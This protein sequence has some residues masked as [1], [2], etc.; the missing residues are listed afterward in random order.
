M[1]IISV[2]IENINSLKGKWAIDFTHDDYAKNNNQFVICG[3][4]GSGK[5]TILDAITLALYGKTPREQKINT[6]VNEVI[7]KGTASCRAVVVYECNNEVITS[8]FSQSK[9]VKSG[10][11]QKI[12]YKVKNDTLGKSD[13]FSTAGDLEKKTTEITGLTYDQ[14]CKSVLLAQ[15]SFSSF[16]KGSEREKAEIL[17]KLNGTED[18]KKAANILWEDVNKKIDSN[19]RKIEKIDS[20]ETLSEE[21]KTELSNEKEE[22]E[23]ALD[24]LDNEKKGLD[25]NIAWK[26]A[27]L[28]KTDEL[29]RAQAKKDEINKQI[30]EFSK[31]KEKLE[32]AEKASKCATQYATYKS[33]FDNIDNINKKLKDASDNLDAA[34]KLKQTFEKQSKVSQEAFEEIKSK[35]DENTKLWTTV[36]KL[37]LEINN[38][39]EKYDENNKR[40]NEAKKQY[41]KAQEDYNS[42]EKAIKD[43]DD[44]IIK[45]TDYLDKHAKDKELDSIIIKLNLKKGD[46]IKHITKIKEFESD[47]NTKSKELTSTNGL[48]EKLNDEIT[49]L[50]NKL[51]EFI[52]SN[53][54][55]I[56][57]ILRK[58][59]LSNGQECPVCGSTAHPF[60]E[61]SRNADDED[62]TDNADNTGIKK[63]SSENGV[64]GRVTQLDE[65][66]AD[67]R[68]T[69][70]SY[71][72][73]ISVLNSEIEGID[74]NLN[75]EKEE[76]VN[77]ILA[78]NEAISSWNFNVDKDDYDNVESNIKSVIEDLTALSK[79]YNDKSDEKEKQENS[80]KENVIKLSGIDLQVLNTNLEKEE[81]L[82][83][84]A[85][86]KL[87]NKKSERNE[88]FS[89]KDVNTE[90][91]NYNEA[92]D[93]AEKTSNTDNDNYH[94]AQTNVEKLKAE[95]ELHTNSAK[96][97]EGKLKEASD[98]LNEAIKSHGFNSI[99]D[100]TE[101]LL[102][103]EELEQ[104]KAEDEKL[105]K[106][107]IECDTNVKNATDSLVKEE[108]KKLTDDSIDILNEKIIEN[109]ENKRKNNQRIGEINKILEDDE[110]EVQKKQEFAA[111][112]LE[113]EKENR[114]YNDIKSIIGVKNGNDVEVFVQR[115]ALHN[116]LDSANHYLQQI[117]PDL[118]L[119]QKPESLECLLHNVN[120]A[121][122]TDDRPV[123]NFSGGETFSISLSL[124][125]ALAEVA[126][127]KMQ[128][129]SLF[130]D[131]GFGTL[132]GDPLEEAI[133]ALKKLSKTGKMLGIITHVPRVIEA[134]DQ[135]IET[136]KSN[137]IS[138][139]K[140]SGIY[141]DGV[142]VQ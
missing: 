127:S 62:G 89:N 104:L 57:S 22:C 78:I 42:F 51:K 49:S 136:Q 69:L 99:E 19:T 117:L 7:C 45:L 81:N 90:E 84:N 26:N 59:C 119:V 125:L 10:K 6:S 67:K 47:K 82:V 17:A 126:S 40:Y 8:E 41:E 35:K 11:L 113:L 33:Y 3:P 123:S 66:I 48:L 86:N 5:T 32:K 34:E 30:E 93:E 102:S 83:N 85:K 52:S 109:E 120:N 46:V 108:A 56:S 91:K 98:K 65:E 16:L 58:N 107:A 88:K 118:E 31:N 142:L 24:D 129:E 112:K 55:S 116:L 131:E 79:Q 29:A 77:D 114:V 53:Y 64:A 18:F 36:R 124:A 38:L 134:F 76:L 75:A 130:L 73:N 94:N 15:G 87:D 133:N 132:S 141:H 21:D 110:K 92:Y 44:N 54:M 2:E 28:K 43:A 97:Y 100:L 63:E 103:D 60:C 20:I 74:N 25:A 37:D 101:S 139:L 128:I 39:K 72:K 9:A 135:Q 13:E 12:S 70:S 137:G 23:K 14:F 111:K 27:I 115:M 105:K 95:K 50:E 1:K 61:N 121:D 140:G 80:K 4:T 122:S 96:E 68:K 106:A 71:E 138:S